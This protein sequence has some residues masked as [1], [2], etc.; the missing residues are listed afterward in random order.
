MKR[1]ENNSPV[2]KNFSENWEVFEKFYKY[3]FQYSN[4]AKDFETQWTTENRLRLVYKTISDLKKLNYV[5]KDKVTGWNQ[6]FDRLFEFVESEQ[7]NRESYGWTTRTELDFKQL[8]SG[9]KVSG[10]IYTQRPYNQSDKN[11]YIIKGQRQHLIITDI[12]GKKLFGPLLV[13]GI[14]VDV[15]PRGS[16]STQEK[17]RIFF[18]NDM[19]IRIN[20]EKKETGE[21]F[22]SKDKTLYKKVTFKEFVQMERNLDHILSLKSGKGTND[23]DNLEWATKEYNSWKAED[24][25]V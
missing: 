20:G 11:K 8:L 18:E 2:P 17:F 19:M 10:D 15:V 16:I 5:P 14:L 9:M 7:T 4:G 21:W 24:E 1:W 6:V 23:E 12:F 25:I 22:N 13:D 3:I